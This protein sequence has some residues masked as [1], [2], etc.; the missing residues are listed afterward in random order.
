M[1]RAT[2]LTSKRGFSRVSAVLL[3]FLLLISLIL[4]SSIHAETEIKA[5]IDHLLPFVGSALVET[6]QSKWDAATED[7]KQFEQLWQAVKAQQTQTG[8]NTNS[9]NVDA[10]LAD[11][12][13]KLKAGGAD[14][15]PALSKLA[16]AVN[17][18]VSDIQDKGKTTTSGASAAKTLL[19]PL[20]KESLAAI[21]QEDW[22]QATKSYQSIVSAWLK[23]ETPIRSENFTVYGQLETQITIVRVALQAD[24][25]RKEQARTEMQKLVTLLS[26][27]ADGKAPADSSVNT[28]NNSLED[29]LVILDSARQETANSK[30][31]LAAD[32]M[33]TFISMWPS[34]EGVVRI[35]S[36]SLYTDIENQMTAVSGLLLSNPP[37]LSKASTIMDD[38]ASKLK[39]IA[40]T[41]HYNAWDAALIL[42]REGLEAI[43]VLSALLSYLNR[44]GNKKQSK[45]IWSGA[46][47]GLVL[48]L[49]LAVILTYTISQAASG[50]ARELLEGI[51]GLVAVGMMLTVGQWLHSKSNTKAWNTYVG[52]Q[53]DSAL[54]RGSLWSLFMIA[55]LAIFREGAETTI[56]YVGMSSSIDPLQ[57]VLGISI[58]SVILAVLA[59][60]IIVLSARLPIRG[61]FLAATVL[62]Y[63]LVLR[64]LGDSIHSLQVA[65]RLPAHASD[66]LPSINWLGMYPSWETFIPQAIVL[67][68]IIWTM[69]RQELHKTRSNKSVSEA[70]R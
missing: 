59:Y 7:L 63:Y 66:H 32:Q 55:G 51:T 17:T 5:D 25:I 10:A 15:K 4:P 43:L 67:L 40:G 8:S 31:N 6:G 46:G 53:V 11:A 45:W 21:Q 30:G 41:H 24:P 58:A 70:N 20:A 1:L 69:V 42:L 16:R 9:D 14:A 65:G 64:F 54:A 62:I 52:R 28:S 39:P 3:T 29:L 60:A 35:S 34:V 36:P 12:Q 68:Y 61:F 56:F 19:L 33:T 22:D 18:Y 23:A 47:A 49:I 2:I 26:D 37:Q 13:A 57:L 50:S 27:Y 38:M 48:S 44:S